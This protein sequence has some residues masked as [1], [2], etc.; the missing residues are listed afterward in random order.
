MR[1]IIRT[2][3]EKDSVFE[4]MSEVT[5]QQAVQLESQREINTELVEQLKVN[6]EKVETFKKKDAEKEEA[7]Q[8]MQNEVDKYQQNVYE[9]KA[10][11]EV[12]TG[13]TMAL[14]MQLAA[15]GYGKSSST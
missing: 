15:F 3:K 5:V 9:V 7:M 1:Q 12:E 6:Q 13:K 10:K 4:E 14:T 8:R 11:L 2:T